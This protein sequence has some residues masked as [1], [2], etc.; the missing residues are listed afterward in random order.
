MAEKRKAQ[1]VLTNVPKAQPV[2]TNLP[3]ETPERAPTSDG[4]PPTMKI[5]KH[6]APRQLDERL[7][8]LRAP[9]SEQAAGF[10]LARHRLAAAGNPRTLLVTSALAGEGKTLCALNL[11]LAL[12]EGGRERVLLVEANTRVPA[13]ANILGLSAVDCLVAQIEAHRKRPNDPWQVTEALGLSLHVAALAADLRQPLL[14]GAGYALA[15][16]ALKRSDYDHI[17]ID[18]PS[19]LGMADINLLAGLA[20]AVVFAARA[21]RTSTRALRQAMDQLAP[22]R[23]VG[24]VLVSF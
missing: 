12:S 6:A 10:R 17:L 5:T 13:L 9:D 21:R 22:A 3:A 11:A 18:G 24:A 14:D 23:V 15:L 4:A 20:D 2:L 1:P 7:V 8:L 16:A 19:V